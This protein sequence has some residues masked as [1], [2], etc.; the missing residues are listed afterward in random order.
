MLRV[1]VAR[2][3][4][5]ARTATSQDVATEAVSVPPAAPDD[6]G[7]VPSVRRRAVPVVVEEPAELERLAG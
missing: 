2:R 5:V 4:H 6:D 3:R 7:I 1:Q